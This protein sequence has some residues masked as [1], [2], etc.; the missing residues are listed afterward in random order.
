MRVVRK[1]TSIADR[2]RSHCPWVDNCV[3]V[4]NLKHFILYIMFLIAGIG[5]LIPLTLICEY[6]GAF[7][8][9]TC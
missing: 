3:A 7:Q 9:G 4:N 5:F 8:T 6:H 1:R 2:L